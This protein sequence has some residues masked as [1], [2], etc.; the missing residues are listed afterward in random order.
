MSSFAQYFFARFI[1]VDTQS[2]SLFISSFPPAHVTQSLFN[3]WC[4][5][6]LFPIWSYYSQTA[7]RTPTLVK[8]W[9][10]VWWLCNA[11]AWLGCPRLLR[12]P[13]LVCLPVRRAMWKGS[14]RHRV[15]ISDGWKRS[16]RWPTGTV[17]HLQATLIGGQQ[18][19]AAARPVIA[20]PTLPGTL[21][22]LLWPLSQ[23]RV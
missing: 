14:R 18:G 19:R 15:F 13:S 1:H 17:A 5:F 21:F 2:N 16:I 23:V 3:C 4:T 10:H 9:T 6:S 11:S 20:G 22:H 7:V 8:Q 12:I